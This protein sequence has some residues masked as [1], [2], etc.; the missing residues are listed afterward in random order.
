MRLLKHL[1][2]SRTDEPTFDGTA[3]DC[4]NSFAITLELPQSCAKPSHWSFFTHSLHGS[5]GLVSY[6]FLHRD[7]QILQGVIFSWSLFCHRWRAAMIYN[8]GLLKIKMREWRPMS[9]IIVIMIYNIS[10]YYQPVTTCWNQYKLVK[11]GCNWLIV[12]WN[13][14]KNPIMVWFWYLKVTFIYLIYFSVIIS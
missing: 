10:Y 8:W 2:L 9:I 5:L 4:N 3:Q 6:S 1:R 12:I 7:R 14:N 13:K 11:T